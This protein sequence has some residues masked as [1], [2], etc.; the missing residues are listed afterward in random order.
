MDA[1]DIILIFLDIDFLPVTLEDKVSRFDA[2]A[3]KNL[4]ILIRNCKL[5][6]G[7]N[8]GIVLSS[9]WRTYGDLD[10]LRKLFKEHFFSNY[11][12]DTTPVIDLNK[13]GLEIKTWI[14]T[15][16]PKMNILKFVIL[17]DC[18]GIGLEEF[19]NKFIQCD[20]KTLFS[21]TELDSALKI[22]L[23]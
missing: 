21:R 10:F 2:N 23:N 9:S 7:K 16:K 20:E 4:E 13:R 1:I 14:E 8:V 12:I 18:A 17:D 3:L 19:G 22:M 6:T 11:L 5:A 15:N